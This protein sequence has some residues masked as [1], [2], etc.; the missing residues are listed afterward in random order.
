MKVEWGT[1]DTDA[2]DAAHA[3]AAGPLQ[4]D[5]AYGSTMLVSGG[6]VV[7]AVIQADGQTVGLA[8][9]VVRRFGN[10][11]GV[12]LCTRGP[13]WLAHLSG[14]DKAHAYRSLTGSMTYAYHGLTGSVTHAYREMPAPNPSSHRKLTE[15]RAHSCGEMTASRGGRAKS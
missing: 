13:L 9:C 4:Q 11:G 10:L 15:T 6:T 5:W 14:K 2:W 3:Q 7:R 1:Q 8:Q 12:A